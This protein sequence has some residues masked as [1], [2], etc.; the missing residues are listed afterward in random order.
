MRNTYW[1]ARLLPALY[2]AVKYKMY[3]PIVPDPEK[4]ERNGIL[5]RHDACKR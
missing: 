1:R 4:M 5:F 3:I 2:E